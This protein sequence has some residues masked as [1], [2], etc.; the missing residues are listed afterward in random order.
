MA[1]C[2]PEVGV[3]RE[4]EAS[5]PSWALQSRWV[6][7][8]LGLPSITL[9]TVKSAQYYL[10]RKDQRMLPQWKR[11]Q[12][13]PSN[14]IVKQSNINLEF[15]FLQHN[16]E[17]NKEFLESSWVILKLKD[18]LQNLRWWLA[19]LRGT[20]F[21]VVS[22][23]K[24]YSGLPCALLTGLGMARRS[25]KLFYVVICT[26]FSTICW[27]PQSWGSYSSLQSC[28]EPTQPPSSL[29]F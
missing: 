25:G 18:I 5:H 13:L 15:S 9:I 10:Q 19:S 8:S 11:N 12:L 3:L 28:P 16:F 24:L 23:F 4:L 22:L 21:S 1:P 26:L 17:K 2:L 27:L 14:Y 7:R 20:K 6:S 29:L